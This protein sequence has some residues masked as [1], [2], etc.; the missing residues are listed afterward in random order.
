MKD[1][2]KGFTCRV[3]VRYCETDQMGVAYHARYLDWFE[4][5]RTG[6]C[7]ACGK[8]YREWEEEGILLPV[9]EAHCRYRSSVRY[10]DEIDIETSVAEVTNVS[11]TFSCRVLRASDGHL[12]AE[13]YTKHAFVSRDGKVL[14]RGCA[15]SDWLRKL[16]EGGESQGER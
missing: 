15:L 11:V 8:P 2:S 7:R 3:R 4:I 5:G 12:A 9:V 13:G 14:R 1:I 10:D 6:L 16:S